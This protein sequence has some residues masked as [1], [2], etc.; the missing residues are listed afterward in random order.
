M[1]GTMENKN[2]IYNKIESGIEGNM[3]GRVIMSADV[4]ILS[5]FTCTEIVQRQEYDVILSG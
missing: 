1:E 3:L 5:D 2:S 4:G